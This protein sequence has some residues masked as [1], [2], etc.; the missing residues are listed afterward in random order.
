MWTTIRV[1]RN[2]I[3]PRV[4]PYGTYWVRHEGSW[5]TVRGPK[6]LYPSGL[7]YYAAVGRDGAVAHI[8]AASLRVVIP[9]P[10]GRNRLRPDGT[11]ASSKGALV[12]PLPARPA[13]VARVEMARAG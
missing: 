3:K 5:R 8:A 2:R 4:A 1:A 13:V 7:P 10:Q 6:R 9:V 12:A 11:P